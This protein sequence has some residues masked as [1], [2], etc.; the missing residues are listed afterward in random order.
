MTKGCA[1]SERGATARPR[2]PRLVLAMHSPLGRRLQ[3][4]YQ[5]DGILINLPGRA[6][7]WR[8][9]LVKR[10][11]VGADEYVT[12]SNGFLTI[13][14]PDDNPHVCRPDGS[15]FHP[16]LEEVDP[17]LLF[18]VE[19]HDEVGLAAMGRRVANG[20][21]GRAACGWGDVRPNGPQS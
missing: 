5:F 15:A 3:Q 1:D 8:R 10:E 11:R 17:E 18:Y 7:D 4:R 16:T 9:H 13:A 21:P 14:P 20:L 12:W 2:R 6:P 19:P